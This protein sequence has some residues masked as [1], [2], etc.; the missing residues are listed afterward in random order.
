MLLGEVHFRFSTK[1]S[2]TEILD[3]IKR[4]KFYVKCNVSF[5]LSVFGFELLT[6]SFPMHPSS[7]P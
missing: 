5:Q 7:T 1:A 2:K 6:Y 4:L 3:L